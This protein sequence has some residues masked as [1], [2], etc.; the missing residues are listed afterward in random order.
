MSDGRKI[1]R[2]NRLQL[3]EIMY[4]QEQQIKKLEEKNNYLKNYI[5]KQSIEL[6]GQK[7]IINLLS[8]LGRSPSSFNLEHTLT[9][10]SNESLNQQERRIAIPNEMVSES[11]NLNDNG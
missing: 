7:E 6:K 5:K 8:K 10:K 4:E 3:L 11:V 1:R 9:I 2:L